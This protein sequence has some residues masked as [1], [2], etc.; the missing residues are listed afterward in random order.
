MRNFAW[1]IV[2]AILV[3]VPSVC[4][5]G[6]ITITVIPAL[7]PNGWAGASAFSA[8]QD[9]ANYAI[10]HG[11]SAYGDPSLPSYYHAGG[12]YSAAQVIVTCFPSWLG[13]VDPG[14]V[15]GAAYS[16]EYGNRMHFGFD[17]KANGGP[18]FSI[19]ML[20]M[21][22]ASSDPLSDLGWSLGAGHFD[23]GPGYVG[24]IYGKNGGSN[25]YITS[26]GDNTQLVD[27]IISRGP[28]N[29]DE[30]GCD[31]DWPGHYP[32]TTFSQ[33][34]AAILHAALESGPPY[35]FT[36]TFTLDGATGSGTF[37]IGVPEPAYALLLGIGLG[38]ISL[39]AWRFKA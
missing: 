9:N 10:E 20:S 17:I 34:Q 27:E 2:G 33:Q 28:G 32:C 1:L 36:A 30:A 21:V 37:H 6:S 7:A 22:M 13:Q 26:P 24:I 5:A 4:L 38:A 23:Y 3:L 11:L 15:V 35:D 16:N 31:G 39:I 14:V 29:S 25:T 8:W 12:N 18:Q 19:S